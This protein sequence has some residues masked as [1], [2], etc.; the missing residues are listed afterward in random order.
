MRVQIS[1]PATDGANGMRRRPLAVI[2]LLPQPSFAAMPC[3][4]LKSASRT[5]KGSAPDKPVHRTRVLAL[6]QALQRSPFLISRCFRMKSCR[7]SADGEDT[8]I[9]WARFAT[10]NGLIIIVNGTAARPTLFYRLIWALCLSLHVYLRTQKTN[11]N[12]HHF[13]PN[14]VSREQRHASR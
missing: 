12:G 2:W 9:A 3:A 11:I 8:K 1:A 4:P 14:N 5:A 6:R 10:R 7:L 13:R